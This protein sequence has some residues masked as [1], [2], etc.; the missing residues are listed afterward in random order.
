MVNHRL[1]KKELPINTEAYGEMSYVDSDG[2]YV[3]SEDNEANTANDQKKSNKPKEP[4][5]RKV[6]KKQKEQ[7]AAADL[8]EPED[9]DETKNKK[10][11]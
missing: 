5:K 6:L 8:Q 3:H 10:G 11:E 2:T 7:D 9:R 1:E 4:D